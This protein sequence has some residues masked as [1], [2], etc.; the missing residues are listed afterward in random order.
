MSLLTYNIGEFE[1]SQ[2]LAEEIR[3]VRPDNVWFLA[4]AEWEWRFDDVLLSALHDV[5]PDTKIL[6]G[7]FDCSYY[8][9]IAK[10][11]NIERSSFIFWPT[12]FFNWGENCLNNEFNY[13]QT[14]NTRFDKP[15]VTYFGNPHL[16]RCHLIDNY[17]RLNIIDKGLITWNI[18]G[19]NFR[20]NYFDN[21][22]IIKDDYLKLLHSYIVTEEYQRCLVDCVAEATSY[23]PFITEKTARP[24]LMK[25]PFVVLGCHKYNEYLKKLG[26]ELYDEIIDYSFDDMP[27]VETRSIFY[28]ETVRNDICNI[29]DYNKTYQ[30]LLPKIEHNYNNIIRIIND[31]TYFPYFISESLKKNK[32]KTSHCE[33]YRYLFE[34]TIPY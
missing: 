18:K 10:K 20:F 19:Y 9:D 7:S 31:K 26:F 29:K 11:Y 28:A 23:V 1:S 5:N 33:R 6:H 21:N 24:L 27:D 14:D 8:D 3:K 34:R 30:M 13:K 25:K 17:A 16:H 15:F 22:L 4:E 32:F 2:I 12:F